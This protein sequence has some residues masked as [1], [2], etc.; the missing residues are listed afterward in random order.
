MWDYN[1]AKGPRVLKTTTEK[2]TAQHDWIRVE[3]PAQGNRV[4]TDFNGVQVLEW[5][6]ANPDRIK[7]GPK[8]SAVTRLAFG[9]GGS[10]QRHRHRNL[11]GRKP[12]ADYRTV[13][14]FWL[15]APYF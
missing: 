14:R 4:R 8:R 11:P 1:D 7:A 15:Y 12:S 3:M 13:T 5:R 2:V 9:A 6:E 10:L